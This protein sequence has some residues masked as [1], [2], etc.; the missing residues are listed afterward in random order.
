MPC[1]RR[2]VGGCQ[3][4]AVSCFMNFVRWPIPKH[5]KTVLEALGILEWG[6][7]QVVTKRI[8]E[9]IISP[10]GHWHSSPKE[11]QLLILM[12]SKLFCHFNRMTGHQTYEDCVRTLG[13]FWM[14]SFANCYQ[15]HYQNK[16]LSH[17]H[18]STIFSKWNAPF[19]KLHFF[20]RRV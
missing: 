18:W 17:D 9:M 12:E 2:L 14:R 20:W 7:L 4:W 3:I 10:K 16:N 5:L 15:E 8:T 6:L 13:N 1:H 19:N 11:M